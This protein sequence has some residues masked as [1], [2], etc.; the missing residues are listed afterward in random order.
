MRSFHK[1]P[2]PVA[3]LDSVRGAA[4][5]LLCATGMLF[6]AVAA[7]AQAPTPS[8]NAVNGKKLYPAN[9]CDTCHGM[10]GEGGSQ[11]PKIVPPGEFASFISQLRTP[12]NKMPPYSN[13]K[14]SDTEIDDIYA[15]LQ[16]L[17][18]TAAPS[19]R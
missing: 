19:S 5:L 9:T 2:V 8:G 15:F 7:N 3:N 11:G 6:L 14:L 13:E 1:P 4:K 10:A 16:S 18:G 12:A 17:A